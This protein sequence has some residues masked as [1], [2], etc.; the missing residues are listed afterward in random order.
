MKKLNRLEE[1]RATLTALSA[2]A[3]RTLTRV[4]T[5]AMLVFA[6]AALTTG[7]VAANRQGAVV[8]LGHSSLGRIIVNSH[9]RTLYLWAHD[10]RSKSTCYGKCASA[11]PALT[12]HG[13]PRAVSGARS[14]LLGT[15]RRSNGR[16]QVTYHGHPLYSFA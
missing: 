12:T 13:R 2:K 6:A 15:T 7:A 4:L 8:K 14:A 1:F 10:K 16:M 11:W 3:S 5:L 9:G